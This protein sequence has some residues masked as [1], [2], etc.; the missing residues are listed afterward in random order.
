M[1]AGWWSSSPFIVCPGVAFTAMLL[2]GSGS[3]LERMQKWIEAGHTRIVAVPAGL[4]LLYVIY[5]A[6]MGIAT[7]AAA[8]TMVVY[9]SAPF[10]LLELWPK[11]EPLVI[12]WIWLPLE[13]GIIREVL[14]TRTAAVDVHYAFAQLLAVDAGIVAFAVWNRTPNIGYRFEWGREGFVKA[15]ANFLLFAAIGIPLGLAI[16]FVHYG[17]SIQKLYLALPLFVGIFL[18]TALPEEFLFRGLIQNWIER[19]TKRPFVSLI[20]ASVIFGASHLN[21]GAPIPN[22][23]YFLMAAI[24]GVFYGRAWRSTGSL[25]ASSITHA[26]VDTIWTVAFR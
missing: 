15:L 1:A 23:R 25:M 11:T 10:V 17:F 8:A 19:G 5:A 20:L 18:L 9:L 6:G 16:H 13:F 3:M 21:N 7:A 26:F 24:A 2:L 12:L 22:Y 14:I 4:W